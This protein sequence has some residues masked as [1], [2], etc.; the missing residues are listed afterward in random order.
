MTSSPEELL[1]YD[2]EHVWHP[3]TSMTEP[4]PVR[5]VES[6]SGVR[7]RLQAAD[8]DRREVIDGMAS[9]WCAIHGYNVPELN[10][11]AEAQHLRGPRGVE[12]ARPAPAVLHADADGDRD[13]D[14]EHQRAEGFADAVR[15]DLGIVN[16][17]EH[18]TD[19]DDGGDDDADTAH[20]S[21]A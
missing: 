20:L 14:R 7:L 6:A 11:A 4:T 9:W 18:A 16:R 5:L 12:R 2:R 17:R 10:A 1:A 8:G 21:Q 19:Q 13:A 3:Y 15:D